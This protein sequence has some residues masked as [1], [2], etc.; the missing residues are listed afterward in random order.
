MPALSMPSPA[1][2]ERLVSINREALAAPRGS[3]EAVYQAACH[4]LSVSRGKLF[5]D[6]KKHCLR[7]VRKARADKGKTCLTSAELDAYAVALSGGFRAN[8]KKIVGLRKADRMLRENAM[9]EAARVD[10]DTGEVKP[11]SQTTI[12]RALKNAG[13]SPEQLRRP[14]PAVPLKSLHPN[15]CWEIDAS[16][17][18]LYYVPEGGLADMSPSVFYKNKPGNF[19]KIK[20]QRLTRYCVTDHASGFIFVWY[21]A[22]GESTKNMAE[23]FLEAIADKG[24]WMM[25]GVPFLLT[26]DPGSGV[27]SP[28]SAFGNLCRRLLIR[29]IVNEAENA[30]AK[31][32]VEKA[33]DIVECEFESGFKFT[34]VPSLDW[35]NA[36]ARRW[37]I[38]FNATEIHS[39]T[40]ETR[41]NVWRRILP[42][43]L[44]MVDAALA[45]E[46][47]TRA[48][49]PREVNGQLQ[50]RF[51]GK[52][53]DVAKVP[54]VM[55]GEKL[56]IACNPF[57]PDVAFVVDEEE[58]HEVL[59]EIP[60]IVMDDYGFAHTARTLGEG[61]Q[62]LPDTR[63]DTNRKRIA[64]LM[65]GA[66]TDH[67]AEAAL[68]KGKPVFAGRL[69]PYKHLD[70]LPNPDIIPMPKRGTALAVDTQ[71]AAAPE[72]PLTHFEAARHLAGQGIEMDA[73]KNRRI[74]HLYPDGVPSAELAAL[75]ERLTSSP[76]LVAVSG[77]RAFEVIEG[78]AA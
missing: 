39:R 27:K 47:L 29:L 4:E 37:C 11:V 35:I 45:R 16:I 20:R 38:H 73:D 17:S 69:D 12:R 44:R 14:T 53:W 26:V 31:G 10:P 13:L 64:R 56:L 46:L 21:V 76:R 25:K 41:M 24:D 22:G 19:E 54:G 67:E 66:K 3:K 59:R 15:H 30:R 28:A 58:G 42:A 40:K 7:P 77:G 68:K 72:K 43:Q 8:D 63:L 50:V 33:H 23:A 9:I 57:R 18:T 61:Y 6:L 71:T 32:Q 65:A 2:L 34:E 62:A 75:A 51:E 52:L 48:P 5:S 74:A 70:D 1:Y 55:I 60:Q 49:K 36:Q 78:G